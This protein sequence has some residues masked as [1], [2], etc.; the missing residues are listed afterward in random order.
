V[1]NQDPRGEAPTNAVYVNAFF[2]DQY[3]VTKEFWDSVMAWALENGYRFDN[4]GYSKAANHPVHTVNWYDAVKWCNARSQKEGLTPCYYE[5]DLGILFK[6]G[7]TLPFVNW[8]ANGYRLPTE[9]EWEKAAR[10]GATGHRF[11]WADSDNITHAQA[12]Y[13]SSTD[14]FY[15]TSS[16][17]GFNPTFTDGV[18]PFT[19]PVG[20]FAPNGYGL[21]DMAGNVWEWC[22][23]WYGSYPSGSVTDPHGPNTG[24]YRVRRGGSWHESAAICQTAKRS[25]LTPEASYD[26]VGLRCVRAAAQ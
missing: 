14:S 18:W 16:T 3:E 5:S 7:R 11:P 20:Y 12:N 25:F 1:F 24:N 6:T 19:S 8:D 4:I 17:R 22:W 2:M 23:D 21:Y 26:Y 10:G 15:D 13:Y 9:A